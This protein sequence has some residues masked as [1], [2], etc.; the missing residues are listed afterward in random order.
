M[1]RTHLSHASGQHNYI[2]EANKI[3]CSAMWCLFQRMVVETLKALCLQTVM[4]HEVYWCR[5]ARKQFL[6]NSFNLFV[7]TRGFCEFMLS[8]FLFHQERNPAFLPSG[9]QNPFYRGKAVHFSFPTRKICCIK[10]R[11]SGLH[12]KSNHFFLLRNP[13]VTQMHPS[14]LFLCMELNSQEF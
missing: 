6:S 14:G 10:Q 2:F 12:G 7:V 8:G 11:N 3:G 1:K 5:Q 4:K 9:N 13:L